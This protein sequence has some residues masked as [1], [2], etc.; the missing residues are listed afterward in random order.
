MKI[1]KIIFILIF[2]TMFAI[3]KVEINDTVFTRQNT[4]LLKWTGYSL[5]SSL[6]ATIIIAILL[7]PVF[8]I[9]YLLGF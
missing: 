5:V 6:I 8:G 1:L 7:L 4:N 9:M 3:G 2:I